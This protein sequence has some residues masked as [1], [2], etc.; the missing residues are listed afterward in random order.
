MNQK[1]YL[2]KAEK[3]QYTELLQVLIRGIDSKDRLMRMEASFLPSVS[4]LICCLVRVRACGITSPPCEMENWNFPCRGVWQRQ[5]SLHVFMDQHVI[6]HNVCVC[7]RVFSFFE[8]EP[9][10]AT[11]VL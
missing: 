8:K 3:T 9:K 7:V 4:T 10:D 2:V 6:E 1:V 11:Y 5:L